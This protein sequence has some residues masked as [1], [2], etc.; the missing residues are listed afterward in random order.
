MPKGQRGGATIK[1][2][3]IIDSMTSELAEVPRETIPDGKGG[4]KIKRRVGRPAVK[5]LSRADWLR[6]QK[7]RRGRTRTMEFAVDQ[8]KE[9]MLCNDNLGEVLTTIIR[10]ATDDNHSNQAVAWKLLADRMLPL[11]YF[12]KDKTT[13]QRATVNITISGL[14]TKEEVEANNVVEGETIDG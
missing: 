10:A 9:R 4:V 11:S 1:V 7:D 6:E 2:G 8:L 5:K 14:D 12:E 13:G 3:T